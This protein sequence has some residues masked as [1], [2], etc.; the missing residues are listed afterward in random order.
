MKAKLVLE[1]GFVFEG[2]LKGSKKDVLGELVFNT[3]V[4][5]YQEVLSDPSYCHQVVVMNF[6]EIGICGINDMDF[7]SVTPHFGG[8]VLNQISDDEDHYESVKSLE[9]FLLE[10]DLSAISGIDTRYLVS[11]IKKHGSLRVL[12]TTSQESNEQLI[13]RVMA[14]KLPVDHVKTCSTSKAY[15][16]ENS[17]YRIVLV[18][19]GVKMNMVRLLHE[20]GF[21]VTIVPYNSAAIDVM[22]YHPDAILISNGPGNPEDVPEVIAL[23]QSLQGK[24]PIF[25]ICLGHQLIAL[26]NMAQTYKMLFGHRGCNHPVRRLRDGSI[27]ITSQNHSYA[28]VEESIEGTKISVT[29]RHVLDGSIEGIEIKEDYVMSVQ[30]HPEGAPGP[31]DCLSFFEEITNIIE[32]FKGGQKDA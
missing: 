19:C 23:I 25:G 10:N 14:Y 4:V 27:M 3:G 6:P 12:I 22:K 28:I 16:Y 15:R 18:D 9:Q 26:A 31:Q 20:R 13:E 29:H 24:L 11:I 7:E 30:F 21:D 5:G 17:G 2:D 1:N 8:L 32:T